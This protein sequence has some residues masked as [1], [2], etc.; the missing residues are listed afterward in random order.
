MNKYTF[1]W[2]KDSIFSQWYPCNFNV[3]NINF[4]CAEQFMMY[5]K[6]LL[7]Q[8]KEAVKRILNSREPEEQKRIGQEV[9]GYRDDVWIPQREVIVY[10]GNY[11]KFTQNPE[12][13]MNLMLTQGTILVEASP[14]DTIWG[15]GLSADDPRAQDEK[16][17][18]GQN[19]LG[20]ILTKLREDFI[21]K[22]KQ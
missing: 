17:W 4:N 10:E 16:S 14:K 22:L 3:N 15:I 2:K 6:A 20:K 7:F 19:L 18:K 13:Y 12:L 1:F 9:K 21:V 8:D 5:R 11:A